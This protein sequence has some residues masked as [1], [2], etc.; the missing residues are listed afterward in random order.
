[1][2]LQV[3]HSRHGAP[4]LGQR[5]AQVVASKVPAGGQGTHSI[6]SNEC[7]IKHHLALFQQPIRPT[8]ATYICSVMV[9]CSLPDPFLRAIQHSFVANLQV[10]KLYLQVCHCRHG[11]PLLGQRPTQVVAGK[12]PAGGQGT[13][14]I[15]R[16]ECLIKHNLA[17]VQQPMGPT[18]ATYICS[19]MVQCSLPDPF[20][21]ATQH[22]FVANLQVGKV[23]LQVCHSG[24]GAPLLGQRP[25]Q[26]VAGK[27]PAGGKA[28]TSQGAMNA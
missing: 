10:G 22:S 5:P 28:P 21:R 8:H 23:Y 1:L 9:Q 27:A 20:L 3:C 25:A 19:V 17:L 14:I 4:L 18:H 24:H 11:A 16:N 26:V 7:L 6:R 15:R 12:A 13:H 2:Y